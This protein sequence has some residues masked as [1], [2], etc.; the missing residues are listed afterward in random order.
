MFWISLPILANFVKQI[1]GLGSAKFYCPVIGL[2]ISNP[3]SAAGALQG[4]KVKYPGS[5]PNPDY[6]DCFKQKLEML[7]LVFLFLTSIITVVDAQDP[8][9]ALNDT[10][11]ANLV[12]CLQRI[13]PQMQVAEP[14]YPGPISPGANLN[15]LAANG[16]DMNTAYQRFKLIKKCYEDNGALKAIALVRGR[17][18]SRYKHVATLLDSKNRDKYFTEP[19]DDY[20]SY[21]FIHMC[22]NLIKWDRMRY[23]WLLRALPT[24]TALIQPYTYY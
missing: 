19:V 17:R 22:R 10:Q 21:K 12:K 4:Y 8:G 1:V 18:S 16:S 2:A 20:R 3:L 23:S 7:A 15:Y 9:K 13:D 14:D 24:S 6:Y 11:I 5:Y